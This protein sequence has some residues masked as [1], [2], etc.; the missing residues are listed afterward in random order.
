M[1]V[2]I[3]KSFHNVIYLKKNTFIFFSVL[4]TLFFSGV[5]FLI[6]KHFNSHHELSLYVIMLV[7]MVAMTC[8]EIFTRKISCII[9]ILLSW[10]TSFL[11]FLTALIFIF[12]SPNFWLINPEIFLHFL[13][14]ALLFSSVGFLWG[15]LWSKYRK[16][17]G[18]FRV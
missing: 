6:E 15:I 5:F 7:W 13:Y 3:S 12:V 1:R 10:F 8:L 4:T 9:F 18:V 17:F 16:V 11:L 14:Y 2:S